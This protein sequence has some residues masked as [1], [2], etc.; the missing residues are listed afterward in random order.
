MI[1]YALTLCLIGFLLS[2]SSEKVNEKSPFTNY[3]SLGLVKDLKYHEV[4]SLIGKENLYRGVEKPGPD[5]SLGRNKSGYFHVRFQLNMTSISDYAV[6]A[7]DLEALGIF[8]KTLNYSFNHQLDDGSFALE[9]P[10]EIRSA[11]FYKPPEPG[12][13]A[14]GTAFF[15]SSLGLSLL[16]LQE[17]E[18]YHHS[19]QTAALR[20][21]IGELEPQI[22]NTLNYLIESEGLLYQIDA[23]APNR[24]LFNALA[25]Y[26]LGKYLSRTDAISIAKGFVWEALAQTDPEQG[27]FI[28]GGGWD[29]SY[30]GVALKLATEI[31][32]M[33]ENSDIK[34]ILRDHI[35]NA[36]IWQISRINRNGEI[37][38]EGNTR[39]FSGGESF[40]GVKKQIDYARTVKALF[41]FGILSGE[42]PI[43]DMAN[44][45]LNYYHKH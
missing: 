3:K 16:S 18:W 23:K 13:L 10:E 45:V 42:Q 5:G 33:A 24:L 36:M 30:N 39:V 9:I 17:S 29:S 4:L 7:Q 44:T 37:S 22:E 15:A 25:Y 11:S 35:V 6:V 41:Y 20:K 19:M 27:Y 26:S 34:D 14:S 31:Y 32:L 43:I 21:V 38:T 1:K 12:D 40:L 28:E 8:V 2:C